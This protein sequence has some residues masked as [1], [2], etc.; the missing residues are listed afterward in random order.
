MGRVQG[1]FTAFRVAAQVRIGDDGNRAMLVWLE[2]VRR[3]A[4]ALLKGPT[5]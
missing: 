4:A 2:L 5:P 1:D 3:E